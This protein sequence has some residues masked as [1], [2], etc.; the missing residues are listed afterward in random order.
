LSCTGPISRIAR[1][2]A[3]LV[4]SAIRFGLFTCAWNL[5]IFEKIG[6][7][8]VSW[9]P[10][11]PSVIDPVSGVIATTGECAQYAAAIA[12]TKLVTPGPFWPMHTPWRP[13]TRA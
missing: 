5:V 6:N 1:S 13:L 10:P 11:R 7:W 2:N 9:K 3:R 12:V 4:I 8:S